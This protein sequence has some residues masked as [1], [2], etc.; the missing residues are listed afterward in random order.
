MFIVLLS[1]IINASNHTKCMSLANPKCK[2]QPTLISLNPS[3]Y[4]Q[5]LHYYPFAVKL[6]RCVGNCNTLNDLYNKV[7]V[8][9][10]TEHLNLSMFNM[11]TGINESKTL[12]KHL[13]CEW[14][15]R[16]DGRK[17]NSDQ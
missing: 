16:F 2:I 13:S 3:E 4:S 7:C 11:I 6:Y 15:C 12:S 1:S 5:E 9:N 10:K 8:P 17:C 14:K